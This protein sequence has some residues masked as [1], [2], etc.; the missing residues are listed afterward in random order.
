MN[1]DKK[2]NPARQKNEEKLRKYLLSKNKDG[3]AN[4]KHR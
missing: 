1:K 4:D 3:K 2:Q